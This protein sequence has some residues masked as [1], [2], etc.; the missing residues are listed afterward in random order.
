MV[1][2]RL[3]VIRSLGRRLLRL[4]ENN[5]AGVRSNGNQGPV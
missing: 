2:K 3:G 1:D 5:T 4:L